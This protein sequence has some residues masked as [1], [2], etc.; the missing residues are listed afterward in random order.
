MPGN[1]E[2]VKYDRPALVGCSALV[3]LR[4]LRLAVATTFRPG[5]TSTLDDAQRIAF[6]EVESVFGIVD[7]PIYPE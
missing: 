6:E 5:D 2:S 4:H 3:R 1:V 7:L